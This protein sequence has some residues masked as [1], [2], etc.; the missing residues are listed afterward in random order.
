MKLT[1]QQLKQ[2]IKE[3]LGNVLNEA[4]FGLFDPGSMSMKPS[5]MTSS[6]I[7]SI[8]KYAQIWPTSDP[9]GLNFKYTDPKDNET[10]YDEI[11]LWDLEPQDLDQL[12]K[13]NDL[14]FAL[15]GKQPTAEEFVNALPG[16]WV[17]N[18]QSVARRGKYV[19]SYLPEWVYEAA[20]IEPIPEEDPEY[21]GEEG[22]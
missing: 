16:Y 9:M 11:K 4:G 3:E 19:V 17:K 14:K 8:H 21:E 18:N 12:A 10:R 7:D 2:I 20:G 5:Q 15:Y 6:P 22:L 1:K 13:R